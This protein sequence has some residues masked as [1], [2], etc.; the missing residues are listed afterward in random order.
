[1]DDHLPLRLDLYL[2]RYGIASSRRQARDLIARGLVQVNGRCLRK[3]APVQPGDR[4]EAAPSAPPTITPNPA[5]SLEVLYQGAALLV[6][7]KPALMPCHPLDSREC[8]TVM[9]GVVAR[10]PETALG[11][12]KPL[13]GLL[14]HRLDNGTSGAL[15]VARSRASLELARNALHRGEIDRRYLALVEGSLDGSIELDAAV[16]HHR[17]SRARMVALKASRGA[18]GRPAVTRIVALRQ[19][20]DYTLVEAR[21]TTGNRHQIRVHLAAAGWPIAGDVQYGA[22]AVPTLA[23]GRFFLHLH[24]LAFPAAISEG[25]NASGGSRRYIV[26]PLPSDLVFTSALASGNPLA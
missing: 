5:L 15:M 7:N 3:A 2:V 18:G 21:P 10:F 11:A 23:A 13:E 1:M 22:R 4:V 24:Q 20:G 8:Q 25:P 6:I 19:L 14:V 9:N 17:H 12:L 16:G 26:A